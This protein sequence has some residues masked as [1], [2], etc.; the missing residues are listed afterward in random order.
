M[1]TSGESDCS[2]KGDLLGSSVEQLGEDYVFVHADNITVAVKQVAF[3]RVTSLSP[4]ANR[5]LAH[6]R[7]GLHRVSAS[8]SIA[9]RKRS[10]SSNSN[11]CGG[12]EAET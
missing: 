12:P 6:S 3:L 8:A 10:N 4:L 7:R 2:N 5:G 11:T 1:L 9:C